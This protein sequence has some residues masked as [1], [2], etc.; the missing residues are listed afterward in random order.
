MICEVQ[1]EC[2]KKCTCFDQPRFN[3]F[4]VNCSNAGI[5]EFP[6]KL[7]WRANYSLLLDGNNIKSMPDT[8]FLSRV[9]FLNLSNNDIS[10]ISSNAVETLQNE[11]IIDLTQ[12]RNLQISTE[13]AARVR[14]GL[15]LGDYVTTCDCDSKWMLDWKIYKNKVNSTGIKCINYGGVDLLD[16]KDKIA[17]KCYVANLTY[18]YVLCVTAFIV[19][20][21]SCVYIIFHVELFIVYAM[22]IR[23]R[24]NRT[25]QSFCNDVYICVHDN[26]THARLW[27]LKS[28]IPYLEGRGYCVYFPCRDEPFGEPLGPSRCDAIDNSRHFI[29]LLTETGFGISKDNQ[30][31]MPSVMNV[32]QEFSHIW[33]SFKKN[34]NRR[35]IIINFDNLSAGNVDSRYLKAF[36]FI[37]FC[38]RFE[39]VVH[40][41]ERKL[42]LAEPREFELHQFP[43]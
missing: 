23:Q 25:K 20:V 12:N 10:Y 43:M 3:H 30:A 34:P 21:L 41:T 7:S 11:L 35:I 5:M 33:Y 28:L 1:E 8:D 13:L 40:L 26:D 19:F 36:I 31:K 2:P 32:E 29:V 9:S 4:V 6:K 27:L 42:G 14:G 18:L 15:I 16:V 37:D 22:V 24:I 38:Q 39:N 17:N